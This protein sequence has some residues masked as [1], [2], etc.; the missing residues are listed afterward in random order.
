MCHTLAHFFADSENQAKT[1]SLE[2]RF[3]E[4]EKTF[5]RGVT[6]DRAVK[7]DYVA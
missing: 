7:I 5:D 1:G 4:F 3:N 6:I 2:D